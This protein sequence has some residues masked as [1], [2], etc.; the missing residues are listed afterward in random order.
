MSMIHRI[1]FFVLFLFFKSQKSFRHSFIRIRETTTLSLSVQLDYQK[2]KPLQ[3]N[4]NLD[5][6]NHLNDMKNSKKFQ[7]ILLFIEII[8][9]QNKITVKQGLHPSPHNI[10]LD[11]ISCNICIK[12]VLEISKNYELVDNIMNYM[13]KVYNI[14]ID[15]IYLY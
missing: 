8:I 10:S 15:V 5:L 12:T 1:R 14:F 7:E 2:Q 11:R 6:N 9:N 4:N 13:K 3:I